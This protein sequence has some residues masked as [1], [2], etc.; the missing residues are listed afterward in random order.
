[1]EVIS[2]ANQKGGTGK[3]TTAVNLAACLALKGKR[4]MLIDMDPQGA[5]TSSF[6]ID[7]KKRKTIYDVLIGE[8]SIEEVLIETE[9][10]LSVVPS[11]IDL[12][13]A[14]VEL[15]NEVGREYILKNI[16]QDV[17]GYEYVIMDTPPSL[18][19]LTLNALVASKDVIIPIQTEYYALE[20]INH[21]M[22]VIE[23]IR[24]R[25]K[26]FLDFRVLLT[27]FDGRLKLSREVKEEVEKFFKGRVFKTI[28]PRNVRVAEA[29]SHGKPVVLYD[30]ACK[31]ASAYFSLADEILREKEEEKNE[32]E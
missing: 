13:G 9:I 23:M 21:L 25:L 20:G 8:R 17:E 10:G 3:T 27:M 11:N 28:I 6:G 2:V 14:E 18:G 7:K 22:R 12:S 24:K 31:G 26:I 15:I 30:R 19:L 4:T 29:P 1:M 5:A 32:R 16:V